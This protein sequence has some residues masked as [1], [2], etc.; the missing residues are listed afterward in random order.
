MFWNRKNK[1]AINQ[2]K[3][4]LQGQKDSREQALENAKFARKFVDELLNDCATE[5]EQQMKIEMA[6][7]MNPEFFESYKE[8]L[9]NIAAKNKIEVLDKLLNTTNKVDDEKLARLEKVKQ[10]IS[11]DKQ[12]ELADK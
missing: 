4:K 1:V 3:E 2:R 5:N 10:I 6:K 9:K 8:Q 7:E 12:I 11:G